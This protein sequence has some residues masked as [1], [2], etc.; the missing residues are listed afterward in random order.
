MSTYKIF[1]TILGGKDSSG[2]LK[3]VRRT[4]ETGV[5]LEDAQAHCQDP[6]T[7]SRTCVLAKTA[8]KYPGKSWFDSYTRE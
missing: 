1:R 7:S 8:R 4:I 5:S 3:V 2:D 6:E